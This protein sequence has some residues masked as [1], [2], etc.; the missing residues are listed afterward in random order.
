[1]KGHSKASR[2]HTHYK[3][4]GEVNFVKVLRVK[5]QIGNAQILSE[6]ARD[7]CEENDPAHQQDMIALYI[8]QQ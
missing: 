1:M 7:H 2:T 5:E 3:K 4:T 8:V 6:T